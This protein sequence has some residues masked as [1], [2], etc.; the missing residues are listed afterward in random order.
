MLLVKNCQCLLLVKKRILDVLKT[1]R[2]YHVDIGC[3]KKAGWSVR[4]I[5]TEFKFKERKVALRID[6]CPVHPEK[7][8]LSHVT[9]I[10][11]PTQH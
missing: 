6:N 3:R 4:E 10:F 2:L 5:N 7:E 1:S 11:L 8:N 9:L